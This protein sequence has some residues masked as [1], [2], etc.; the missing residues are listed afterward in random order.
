M[1]SHYLLDEWLK[2]AA[3]QGTDRTKYYLKV[4]G[5]MTFPAKLIAE[6]SWYLYNS[7]HK[8]GR[9]NGGLRLEN[10]SFFYHDL[11][12]KTP[13]YNH[14]RIW[15]WDLGI[16]MTQDRDRSR[17]LSIPILQD[18]ARRCSQVFTEWINQHALFQAGVGMSAPEPLYPKPHICTHTH[19]QAYNARGHLTQQEPERGGR[20]PAATRLG[21]GSLCTFLP[22]CS[23]LLSLP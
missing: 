11:P 3:I 10:A 14:G 13:D 21:A 17:T 7:C 23:W 18:L 16:E 15:W 12:C 19:T 22:L 20:D 1:L 5:L 9:K 8:G 2:D 6:V 4:S